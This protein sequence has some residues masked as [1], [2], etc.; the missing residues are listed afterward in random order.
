[1]MFEQLRLI[2]E[3]HVEGFEMPDKCVEIGFRIAEA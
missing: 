3:T 1:M 2:L